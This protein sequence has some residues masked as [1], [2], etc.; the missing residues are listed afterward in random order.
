MKTH[1]WSLVITTAALVFCHNANGQVPYTL[2]ASLTNGTFVRSVTAADVNHDGKSDLI[3][4]RG[5]P[6]MLY[7]W[8]NSGGGIFVSN[9]VMPLA[10]FPIKSSRQM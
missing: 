1:G 6:S 4:V 9:A 3:C 7:I 10:L 2:S 5:N 8:T